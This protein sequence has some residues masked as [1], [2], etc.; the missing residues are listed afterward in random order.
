[1][2]T[3]LWVMAAFLVGAPIVGIWLINRS[4]EKKMADIYQ[5]HQDDMRTIYTQHRERMEEIY[6]RYKA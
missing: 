5:K 2:Q 3:L 4:H 6:E 1:M